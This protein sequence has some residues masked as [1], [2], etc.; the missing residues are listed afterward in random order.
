M[1]ACEA[2]IRA[3]IEKGGPISFARFLELALYHP[4]HGY[5][6]SGTPRTG[7][8]GDFLTAPTTGPALGRVLA[9]LAEHVWLQTGALEGFLIVE[10]GAGE[11]WLLKDVLDSLPTHLACAAQPV[12]IEPLAALRTRQQ[13]RLGGRKV[14]WVTRET[15]LPRCPGFYFSNELLDALPFHRLVRRGQEWRELGVGVEG[16]GLVFVDLPVSEDAAAEARQLP[17]L[18]EGFVAEVRPLAQRWLACLANHLPSGLI[19]TM[20]YGYMREQLWRWPQGT[21]RCYQNHRCDT[22]PLETPGAK[23][24]TSHVDFSALAAAGEAAGLRVLGPVLLERFLVR[25]AAR[26]LQ[27]MEGNPDS[28]FLRNFQY[29]IRPESFGAAFQVMGFAAGALR[30]QPL[31]GFEDAWTI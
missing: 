28:H 10:Q 9:E 20:D 27:R 5:Y 3:E 12:I 18:P 8:R 15:E 30:E 13:A 19:L 22:Q 2:L 31:P 4:E 1:M 7:Q 21:L 14:R 23:D 25:A 17:P 11:G 16:G 24:I 26:I 6:A 29:L